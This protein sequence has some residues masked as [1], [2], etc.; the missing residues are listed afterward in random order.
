MRLANLF[1]Q[2]PVAS[3]LFAAAIVLLGLISYRQLPVSP[4]PA[5]DF[6]M[7]VVTASLPGASPGSMAATPLERALGSIAGIKRISSNSNQGSTQIRLEFE[8]DRNVDEAARDVQASINAVRAQLPSGMPGNPT[9]RK[10]NPSQMPV[11]ALALSS[12]SLS[13]P[14]LYDSAATI[15]SQKILQIQ[16]VG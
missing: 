13:A 9:Y 15:L 12:S 11:M 6:R 1:I 10:F 3:G 16:G 5:V 7:I 14:E 8:L 4:L 2:R